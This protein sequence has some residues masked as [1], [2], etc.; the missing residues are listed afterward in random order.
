VIF[1]PLNAEK[2]GNQYH[3]KDN[4]NN[5]KNNNNQ[6]DKAQQK[7]NKL[8]TLGLLSDDFNTI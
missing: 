2:R 1:C 5:N 3:T 6:E 7:S 4:F 8:F